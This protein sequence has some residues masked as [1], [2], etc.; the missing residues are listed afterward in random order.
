LCLLGSL[1]GCNYAV[2]QLSCNRDGDCAA[3]SYC[4][5]SVGICVLTLDG[6]VPGADA[7][8]EEDA[9]APTPDSG[10][11]GVD[12]ASTGLDAAAPGLDA[13]APNAD[14][15]SLGQDGGRDAGGDSGV[16]AGGPDASACSPTGA[17][18]PN[19]TR[20]GLCKSGVCQSC[21]E[22]PDAGGS[23]DN[24]CSSPTGYGAGSICVGGACIIGNCHSHADC[25]GGICGLNR[26]N[27]CSPCNSDLQCQAFFGVG[28]MCDDTG[29]CQ[30]N[31]CTT[32]GTVCGAGHLCCDNPSGPGPFACIE[33]T[34]CGDSMCM[35]VGTSCV[36]NSCTANSPNSSST[37][38][39]NPDQ[40]KGDDVK[41]V[42]SSDHPFRTITRALEA[43]GRPGS[44]TTISVV[45]G[46]LSALTGE[47]FPLVVDKNITIDGG[48]AA[49]QTPSG[50]AGFILLGGAKLTTFN[51]SSI[52]KL[53]IAVGIRVMGPGT[54]ITSVDVKDFK[55]DGVAVG[56][57]GA[58][59]LIDV[60]STAND[61]NGLLVLADGTASV[62]TS[63]GGISRFDYNGDN[64]ILITGKG[65]VTATGNI[66]ASTNGGSGLFVEQVNPSGT[67]SAT[68]I[69]LSANKDQGITV[70]GGSH[71][72]L[73]G[74]SVTG[75][76]LNG[77][78][79]GTYVDG[80]LRDSGISGISLG[81]AGD[82]GGN[83]LQD[84]GSPNG[85]AGVCLDIQADGQLE[86]RG[87]RFGAIDCSNTT[88]GLT[89]NTTCSGKV[90]V[91]IKGKGNIDTASCTH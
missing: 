73:R 56:A 61:G 82:L 79:V 42:G 91:S 1:G 80:Y 35:T 8:L 27:V 7:A 46:T 77:V 49:L 32:K 38:F 60:T 57:G 22:S 5:T 4:N 87:N 14:A 67:V 71:L 65:Y 55:G 88:S 15:A 20:K 85:G 30:T 16:D 47:K 41:G 86:A 24:A 23:D 48:K 53:Q 37:Y 63:T 78:Y 18:C 90:D 25:A 34:C 44:P 50:T 2:S 45:S 69:T 12:A 62:S 75:N 81:V 26:R 70:F 21:V 52:D 59:D 83:K 40:S 28:Q 13:G 58:V 39:V 68:D 76:T 11:P 84:T 74:G 6:A 64:G 66:T 33:G 51:L 72:R 89:S 29:V 31:A 10:S 9:G 36:H 54:S 17:A 3:G 19:G 43:I